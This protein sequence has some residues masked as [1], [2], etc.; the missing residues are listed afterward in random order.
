MPTAILAPPKMARIATYTGLRDAVRKTINVGKRRAQEAVEREKVR[1]SW[2]IGRLINEHILLNRVRADYGAKVIRRLSSDLGISSSE[3]NR[4]REFAKAY[5]IDAAPRQLPWAHF[6]ELLTVNS[7]EKREELTA[8]AAKNR[9]SQKELRREIRQSKSAGKMP[10]SGIS[11]TL[12]PVPLGK[13]GVYRVAEYNGKKYY[14]LGFSVHIG[15]R[16]KAPKITDP[17]EEALYYYNA[18]VLSVYDGDT[19]HA[20]IDLGFGV[21]LEQRL[22]LRRLNAAELPSADG[23]KAKRILNKI[24][25]QDGGRILIKTSKSDDQYGRYLADIWAA[26]VSIDPQLLRSGVFTVRGDA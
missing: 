20:L 12:K 26:G 6:K 7:K 14:D 16:G 11:K 9:W 13:P 5:S 21:V 19:F 10:E 22:R 2:Q 25:M 8:K 3:L 24:L 23:E 18:Q 1:T 15:M 4:M 17:P